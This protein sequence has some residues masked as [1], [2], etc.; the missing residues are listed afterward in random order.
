MC[1][2]KGIGM[3]KPKKKKVP[4]PKFFAVRLQL[5]GLEPEPAAV[6]DLERAGPRAARPQPSPCK[7]LVNDLEQQAWLL[8]QEAAEARAAVAKAKADFE[9]AF[10][11]NNAVLARHVQG[12]AVD[13]V[14]GAP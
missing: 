14:D 3:N 12:Q 7:Q 9:L 11:V 8:D 4:V 5:R 13:V 2:H 10:K 6:V 1:R